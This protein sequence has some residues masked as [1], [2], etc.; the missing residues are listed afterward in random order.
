MWEAKEI[1]LFCVVWIKKKKKKIH[2]PFSSSKGQLSVCQHTISSFS[3]G[4][5]LP[6]LH[7]KWGKNKNILPVTEYERNSHP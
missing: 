3:G 4:I 2:L 1:C 6:A 7:L 5:L